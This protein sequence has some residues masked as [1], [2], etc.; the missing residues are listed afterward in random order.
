MQKWTKDGGLAQQV[1]STEIPKHAVSQISSWL[2]RNKIKTGVSACCFKLTGSPLRKGGG[3]LKTYNISCYMSI[4]SQFKKIILFQ[5][6]IISFAILKL[7][8]LIKC[9]HMVLKCKS[10]SLCM[11]SHIYIFITIILYLLGFPDGSDGKNNLPA[12]QETQVRSLDQEDSPGE[13]N[14]KPL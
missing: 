14:G 4:I 10:S 9:Y 6:G 7:V 12:M 5:N 2:N 1:N 3:D 8:N 11:F 13:G